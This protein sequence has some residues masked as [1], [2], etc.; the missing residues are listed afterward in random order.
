MRSFVL[1]CV[2]IPGT[3]FRPGTEAQA[4]DTPSWMA[5]PGVLW[6]MGEQTHQAVLQPPKEVGRI[7]PVEAEGERQCGLP[8]LHALGGHILSELHGTER[9]WLADQ[10][11]PLVILLAGCCHEVLCVCLAV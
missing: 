2:S 10:Y 7:V 5:L 6:E 4:V 3:V 8:Q 1:I 11:Y 9:A